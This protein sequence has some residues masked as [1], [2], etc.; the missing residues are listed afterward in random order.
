M[1]E[2]TRSRVLRDGVE[3]GKAMGNALFLYEELSGREQRLIREAASNQGM[4]NV[5]ISRIGIIDADH[6]KR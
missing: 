6:R 4:T 3:I 2:V 5:T 1:F